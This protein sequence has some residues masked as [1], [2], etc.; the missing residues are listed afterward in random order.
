MPAIAVNYVRE[1]IKNSKRRERKRR[2]EQ[3]KF[4][5]VIINY[6]QPHRRHFFFLAI[7]ENRGYVYMYILQKN[8]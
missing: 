3:A 2:P 4:S 1:T 6:F 5:N 7:Y 8:I